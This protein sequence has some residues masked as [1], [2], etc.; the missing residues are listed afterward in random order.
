MSTSTI[1]IGAATVC[2][3]AAAYYQHVRSKQSLPLPPGPAGDWIIGNLRQM[4]SSYLWLT[5]AEWGRKYG[6]LTYLNVL[7]QPILIIN[8]HEAAVDLLEKRSAVYSDRPP[9]TMAKLSGQHA[10]TAL[11][12][13][14]SLH[15]QHRKLF[16]HALH[17]KVVA[18]SYAPLQERMAR[19]LV[20]SLLE[21][22]DDY[23]QLIRRS[24]GEVIQIVT[25]GDFMDGKTDLVDLATANVKNFG[26]SIAGYA[27]DLIPWLIY[28]PDWFPGTQFK[29]DAE[30]FRELA[31]DAV[32]QG[33]NMVKRQVESDVAPNC[34]VTAALE[35]KQ[36]DEEAIAGAAFTLFGAGSETTAGTLSVFMLAMLLY[37]VVQAKVRAELD[38]VF[39]DRFPDVG[40]RE[41]TPYLNAVLLEV[42][43]WHPIIPAG[44]PRQL[45]QHDTYNGYHIPSGTFVIYNAW[46]ILNDETRYPDPE[47]FNPDRFLS[48]EYMDSDKGKEGGIREGGNVPPNPWEVAFG[49]GR[50]SCQGI[51]FVESGVWIVMATML[52]TF[53]ILP[54]LDSNNAMPVA[55]EETWQGGTFRS[56]EHVYRIKEAAL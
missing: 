45:K 20:I 40:G 17:P 22:P 49:Y 12:P 24:Q 36:A 42:L 55:H 15:R 13:F 48:A 10:S 38:Q 6:P 27:V 56:Q 47:T 14:G 21:N 3:A 11:I 4:P 32:W 52:S 35:D 44:I 33:F 18:K 54:K 53:E 9:F 26:A 28:L 25:Y 7:G 1:F 19:R 41:S 50:R 51:P 43:R 34:F 37:P 16:A 39:G 8:T 23:V 29:R 5:F 46:G 31:H 2:L 30:K